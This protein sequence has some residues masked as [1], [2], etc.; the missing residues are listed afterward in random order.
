MGR[1][2]RGWAAGWRDDETTRGR[3]KETRRGNGSASLFT[4]LTSQYGKEEEG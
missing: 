1:D 3:R 4:S 2:G